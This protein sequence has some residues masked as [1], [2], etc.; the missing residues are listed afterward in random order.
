MLSIITATY[1]SSSHIVDCLNSVKQ[2]ELSVEHII[3]DGK[4]NDNTLGIVNTYPHVV[5]VISESDRGIYDAMNKGIE[6]TS[7]EIIGILNSDDFYV[8]KQVLSKVAEVFENKNIDSCYGDL[9]YI[10][11]TNTFK[12]IRNWKAGA[13]CYRKF[14]WGWMP[15]HPTFFVRR[16][17]YERYGTFDLDFGSAADYELMLRFLVKHG[18]TSK[19]IPE[20]LVKMRSGG[21]SNASLRNRIKAN[22]MDRKAWKVNDLKPYPWTIYLKPLRK[23]MQFI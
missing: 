9:V 7:G 23:I 17:I 1:N 5:K 10:D 16:S 11:Y 6:L 14:Y 13:Y 3:V 12:V 4:S 18:I 8:D 15:P 19:Y 21:I 2:Q 22:L 20:V